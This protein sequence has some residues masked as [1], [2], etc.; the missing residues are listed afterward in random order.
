MPPAAKSKGAAANGAAPK[1][2]AQKPESSTN[3]TTTP[4]HESV[5]DNAGSTSGKPDKAAYDA[6]QD[7][8]KKSI[9]ALQV[10]LVRGNSDV[11]CHAVGAQPIA[12]PQCGRRSDL[13]TRVAR[14][15]SGGRNFALSW[16]GSVA[17]RRTAKPPVAR[18]W[19]SSRHSTRLSRGR[20]ACYRY[21]YPV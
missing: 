6:E 12:S 20:Y 13:G 9:D 1:A 4:V 10:K 11:V 18:S 8:L 16:T 17:S 3:G 19:S 14:R 21:V 5:K 7:Q 15:M 2:K